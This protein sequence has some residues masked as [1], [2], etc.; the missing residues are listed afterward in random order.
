MQPDIGQA[1]ALDMP[2]RA[3]DAIEE[4][5]RPDQPDI[6][7]GSGL[8]GKMLA[9]PEADLEPQRTRAVTVGIEQ[10]RRR[11]RPGGNGDAWQ[12]RLDERRLPN[13]QLMPLLPPVQAAKGG[14]VGRNQATAAFSAS[15]R[16]SFSQLKPPSASGVRPK[17]P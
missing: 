16:S 14:R 1:R 10:R 7:I 8:R 3:D 2:E 4:R 13:P 11:Q 12:Q 6:G 15:T 5:L 9:R 17:W